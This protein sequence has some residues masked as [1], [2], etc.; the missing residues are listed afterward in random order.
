MEEL[1]ASRLNRII[2]LRRV[3]GKITSNNQFHSKILI[4]FVI[5]H[6]SQFRLGMGHFGIKRRP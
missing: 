6:W 3:L 1:G 2:W 5:I 4:L